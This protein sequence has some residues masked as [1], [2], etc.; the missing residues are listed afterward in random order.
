MKDK[1][2]EQSSKYTAVSLSTNA[3]FSVGPTEEPRT[4][5]ENSTKK[6]TKIN[7]CILIWNL[8]KE[9]NVLTDSEKDNSRL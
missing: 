3:L 7:T 5:H 8:T 9:S 4:Y 2:S 1:N 6:S